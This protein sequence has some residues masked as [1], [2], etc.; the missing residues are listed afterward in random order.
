MGGEVSLCF[1]SLI[2]S[3]FTSTA[4]GFRAAFPSFMTI[5]GSV[6]MKA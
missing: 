2:G 4:S 1:F 6:V 5:T 3:P